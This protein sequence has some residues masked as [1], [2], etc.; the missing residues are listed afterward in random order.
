MV[1]VKTVTGTV[2]GMAEKGDGSCRVSCMIHTLF[3]S[4]SPTHP[5]I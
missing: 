5:K 1:P 4:D 3:M 2:D